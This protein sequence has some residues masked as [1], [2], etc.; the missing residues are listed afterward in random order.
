MTYFRIPLPSEQRNRLIWRLVILREETYWPT[1]SQTENYVTK[2]SQRYYNS[3][4]ITAH[5]GLV[6]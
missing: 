1:Q 6:M 2:L 4:S 3:V 5:G